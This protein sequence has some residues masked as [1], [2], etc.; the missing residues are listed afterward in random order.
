MPCLFTGLAKND[1][2]MSM[3][4]LFSQ[5]FGHF[6]SLASSRKWGGGGGG[7][8]NLTRKQSNMI[9]WSIFERYN[10]K[11][12]IFQ[13]VWLFSLKYEEKPNNRY[14]WRV[15]STKTPLLWENC[16][17]LDCFLETEVTTLIYR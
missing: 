5:L 3:L 7:R 1:E 4:V 8:T 6:E 9:F 10:N 14:L 17:F 13:R 12:T 2:I 15:S 16:G 11:V